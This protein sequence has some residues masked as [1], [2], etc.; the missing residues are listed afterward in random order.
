MTPSRKHL[1]KSL[2]HGS[3]HA[4]VNHCFKSDVLKG[5][6]VKK[7]GGL[8]CSEVAK[9]CSLKV[10]SI[11]RLPIESFEKF[12]W[13][14]LFTELEEYA[15]VLYFILTCATKTKRKRHADPEI[16]IGTII[17]ILCKHRCSTL[18]LLQKLMSVVLYSSHTAKQ[19]SP[20]VISINVLY[21]KLVLILYYDILYCRSTLAY[22]N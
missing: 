9:L 16:I 6:I 22:R 21:I 17:A 4:M 3:R 10:N 2:F 18:S 8:V 11:L 1:A 5:I 13:K 19:V 14:T 12:S 20:H 7:L 15:P